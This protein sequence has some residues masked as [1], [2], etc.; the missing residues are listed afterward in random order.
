MVLSERSSSTAVSEID[1][2]EL[3]ALARE[4]RGNVIQ[5]NDPRYNA[6]R[7]VFN[8]AID[9]YPGAI[10]QVADA[11]DVAKTIA[12][13]RERGLPIAVRGGGHHT[14]GYGV[15]DDGI[16]I[17]LQLLKSVKVDLERRVAVAGT[18]LR[19]AEYVNAVERYGMVSPVGDA[20]HTGIAGLTLGGGYG[21][22][23]GK[24]GMV[25]DNV[26]AAQIVTA[27]GRILRVSAERF[28]QPD[29]F[30]ALRGGSGNFGVVT[31]FEYKLT[32]QAQVLG[33]MLVYPFP[34]ARDILRLYRDFTAGAPDEITTYAALASMPDGTPIVAIML[35]YSGADLAE[36]ERVIA[37]LRAAGP[38]VD[39]LHPMAYEELA[40]MTDPFAGEG[41]GHEDTW[42]NMPALSAETLDDLLALA[43]PAR[44]HGSSI[45][46]K[47]LNGAARRVDPM[48]TA[49]PHRHAPYSIVPLAA[50]Q[51]GQETAQLYAWVDQVRAMIGPRAVGVYVNGAEHD[52]AR[53][54]YGVNYPRL[55]GIKRRYDPDNVFHSTFNIDPNPR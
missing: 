8:A 7:K 51:P 26:V 41:F 32:P 4:L 6:E 3:A 14:A 35:C 28:E 13:A 37:P 49:F 36:G 46:I 48:A 1:R 52:S 50:W 17:D 16:V 38:V 25:I 40:H 27:D 44:S 15:I 5:P 2:F 42:L 29:L 22:L 9:R 33:G 47:Q 54:V 55:V 19:A 21:W 12:F 24:L 23:S 11:E 34:M 31:Q 53:A 10:V 30:W 18:G 39:T 20:A 45:I 43:D